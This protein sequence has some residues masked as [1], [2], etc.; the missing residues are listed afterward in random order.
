MTLEQSWSVP[1][2]RWKLIFLCL[3]IAGLGAYGASRLMTPAYQSSSLVEASIH[4]NNNQTDIN[5]LLAGEQL[6]QTEAQ[7]AVSDPI[8]REVAS[9]YPGL[10]AQQLAKEVITAPR[11]GTLLFEIDVSD[12]SPTRAATLANDIAGT[13][14]KQ[15]IRQTQQDNSQSEQQFQLDLQQTQQQ[16]D[17][18]TNRIA[19][20]QVKKGNG[21]QISIL[22]AQLNGLQQHYS[23][24][25]ILLAQL[26]LTETQNGKLLSIVQSAQPASTPTRP[27]VPLNIAVGLSIG[28]LNGLSLAILFELLDTRV[29]TGEALTQLTGWPVLAT[30]WRVNSSKNKKD[31]HNHDAVVNPTEHSPNIESYRILRTSI[32]FSIIDKPLRLIM[33][34]S[35]APHEGKS[36]TAANLAI[37]MAKAGKKTLLIDADLRRPVVGKIFGLSTFKMGLSNAIVAYAELQSAA[38]T[39]STRL[40]SAQVPSPASFSLTSYTQAVSIPNLLVMPT[41]P[42]PPNPPE[43]L[44]SKAME[45]FF[46]ALTDFG[47]EV[48]IFDAPPM[49]GL[50]DANILA[51][52][53]DGV[54]MVVDITNAN[55]KN[56]K[57]VK[58]LLAQSGS[59][60]L[61]C[62]V[63]KQPESRRDSAYSYYYAY[64]SKG[65]QNSH[66]PSMPAPTA[67]SSSPGWQTSWTPGTSASDTD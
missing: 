11:A 13:L 3:M 60:V 25:Q 26:K 22:E 36:T 24:W 18:I 48:V 66:V 20:L 21:A 40:S 53:V 32:G 23:Q 38:S 63:N 5:S 54:L 52:K 65:M 28:L 46:T 12:S 15:Q 56:L 16:I 19:A 35:A 55:K 34:T 45:H 50:S 61:G 42:L 8:L 33:V 37:F 31:K 27:N 9:H 67:Q 51:P 7:L 2:K 29:R 41:G 49:L 58:A 14:I 62:V 39:S 47:A 59:R 43:L 64:Q 30:V 57:Q 10:T 6:V 17:T 44:D 1:I 4:S